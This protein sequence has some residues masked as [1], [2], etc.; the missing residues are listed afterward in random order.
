MPANDKSRCKA[1]VQIDEISG[2]ETPSWW[3]AARLC[4]HAGQT[5][6]LIGMPKLNADAEI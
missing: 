1:E 3:G 4:R 6:T 5:D 2:A